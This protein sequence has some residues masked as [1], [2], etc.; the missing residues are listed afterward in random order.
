MLYFGD[1]S[2]KFHFNWRDLDPGY[3]LGIEKRLGNSWGV[4]VNAYWGFLNGNDR[5]GDFQENL[6]TDNPNFQRSLNFETDV[7]DLS[8]LFTFYTNN[9][10]IFRRDAFLSPYFF[11]G[12]G[13]TQFRVFADLFWGNNNENRYYYWSDNTIRTESEATGNANTPIIE[14]DGVYE[15]DI[16]NIGTEVDKYQTLIL[17]V[18]VGLGLNFRISERFAAQL[19]VTAKYAFS[20]Y[21]DDVSGD[22][23]SSYDN[24]YQAYAGNP[25]NYD[26]TQLR[27]NENGLDDI[28]FYP[29][30]S[31][32]YS[33]G[34][35]AKKF[36]APVIFRNHTRHDVSQVEGEESILLGDMT[37][38]ASTTDAANETMGTAFSAGGASEATSSASEDVNVRPNQNATDP[39]TSEEV[40]ETKSLEDSTP[41]EEV[42]DTIAAAK[43]TNGIEEVAENATEETKDK[44]EEVVENT[45]E[46][47]KDKV[48][49]VVENTTEETKDKVEGVAE[50]ATEETKDK[51]EEVAENA[52][53]ETKD[54]VEEVAENA[55]EET[56]DKVEEVVENTTE[57]TKDKVEEVVEDINPTIEDVIGTVKSTP[58]TG[59]NDVLN[60]GTGTASPASQ[61]PIVV[62]TSLDPNETI[63][64][65]LIA[66]TDFLVE[67]TKTP[68][69]S[70]HPITGVNDTVFIV[71]RDTVYIE[72]MNEQEVSNKLDDLEKLMKEVETAAKNPNVT[73]SQLEDR[74]HSLER[75]LAKLEKQPQ[76]REAELRY[77]L[78][79]KQL[80]MLR[81]QK[82]RAQWST[83]KDD[84]A[85][86]VSPD[87]L[88]LQNEIRE[89]RF[90]LDRYRIMASA[91]P[92]EALILDQY[93][94]IEQKMDSLKTNEL[95]SIDMRIK[96]LEQGIQ[97]SGTGNTTPAPTATPK[98]NNVEMLDAV[99]KQLLTLNTELEKLKLDNA[100]YQKQL[101]E[102]R[103]KEAVVVVESPKPV[104]EPPKTVVI[105]KPAPVVDRLGTLLS[106]LKKERVY[107]NSGQRLL[108]DSHRSQLASVASLLREHPDL[109]V[110]VTG[111]ADRSGNPERN[112]IL[113]Q[114]RAFAVR[115]YLMQQSGAGSRQIITN[116]LGE[117]NPASGNVNRSGNALDRRVEVEF[118][119]IR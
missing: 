17:H 49:E 11:A 95:A 113:S 1:L 72:P 10:K 91:G 104:A 30:L 2:H 114:K 60:V 51:V 29:S 62:S 110:I 101:E 82:R 8:L 34:S 115:D 86:P 70:T 40:S 92:E 119:R 71:T 99:Y 38:T 88:A 89:L 50:N 39:A 52:T 7:R 78:M 117:A 3:S 106:S 61:E 4:G 53:E 14:Q 76:N 6:L 97:N 47:T 90:D 45:T 44:V 19:S 66:S 68:Q 85:A 75:E 48:E 13:G 31:V 65:T 79:K 41:W 12:V 64:R 83:N 67:E 32:S 102:L 57:E 15:S 112:L 46:E 36:K 118:I 96:M 56:K 18:P 28:Y 84:E 23:R 109:G 5:T 108:S 73:D 98:N 93:K 55:T 116:Y 22:Y 69:V 54:K 81:R 42:S 103:S 94:K 25:S 111:Y 77:R 9:G 16:T 43:G 33:F 35:P 37:E 58:S 26:A 80:R 20:D 24:D 59:T 21:L 100:N 63:E 105:E 107:F 27:G 74:V 87:Y